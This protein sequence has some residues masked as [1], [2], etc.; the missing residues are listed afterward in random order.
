MSWLDFTE[1]R[2]CG[3]LVQLVEKLLL[4]RVVWMLRRLSQLSLLFYCCNTLVV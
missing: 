4:A 2:G 3:H 1:E